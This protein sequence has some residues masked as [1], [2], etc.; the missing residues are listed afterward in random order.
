MGLNTI[1]GLPVHVL[2][3]HA[4]VVLL[5]LAAIA[6]ALVAVWAGARR[7]HGLLALVFTFVATLTVPVATSSGEA[8]AERFSRKTPAVRT[9]TSIGS[10]LLPWAA[11]M[12]L[13]LALLVA[14]DIYRRAV[15]PAAAP[16]EPLS[17][18]ERWLVGRL[19]VGAR[20]PGPRS[21]LRPLSL[22]AAALAFVSAVGAGVTVVRIGDSGARAAWGQR[23]DLSPVNAGR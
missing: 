2:V 10:S 23:S 7:R 8:L 5:P 21:W 6:T 4:V 14:V 1:S 9:H 19:P 16:P 22:L 12:G 18:P 13:T 15:A 3:V 17:R 11:V 20:R